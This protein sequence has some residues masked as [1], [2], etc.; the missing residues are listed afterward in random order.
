MAEKL[1]A[2]DRC[3]FIQRGR[4]LRCIVVESLELRARGEQLLIPVQRIINRRKATALIDR[5]GQVMPQPKT[6]WIKRGE[7][8]KLPS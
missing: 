4:K 5:P 8:R 7:L 1:I 3:H 6:R 2:G